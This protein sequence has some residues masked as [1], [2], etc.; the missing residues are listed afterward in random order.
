MELQKCMPHPDIRGGTYD[1]GILDSQ[2][3]N[4]Q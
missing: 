3:C 4:M 1:S 2:T